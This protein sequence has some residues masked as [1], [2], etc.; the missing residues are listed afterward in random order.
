MRATGR[1][2]RAALCRRQVVA[3]HILH[4]YQSA[5]WR[6]TPGIPGKMI[7]SAFS[8]S[9]LAFVRISV[10]PFAIQFVVVLVDRQIH[11]PSHAAFSAIYT[12]ICA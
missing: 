12:C 3:L 1:C 9:R 11:R 5:F 2:F 8:I 7:R 10:D 6:L 4:S